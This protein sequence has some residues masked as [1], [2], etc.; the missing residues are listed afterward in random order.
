MNA[1]E[2]DRLIRFNNRPKMSRSRS[3]SLDSAVH[4]DWE[5]ESVEGFE[6]KKGEPDHGENKHSEIAEKGEPG[7][8][9]EQPRTTQ[10]ETLFPFRKE[11]FGKFWSIKIPTKRNT[12]SRLKIDI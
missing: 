7:Q 11:T 12:K 5:E 3:G 2:E 10:G 6:T 9:I 8:E 1:Q 4:S